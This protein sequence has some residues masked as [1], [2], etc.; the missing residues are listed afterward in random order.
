LK[1]AIAQLAPL[2]AQPG[3]DYVVVARHAAFDRPYPDIIADLHKAFSILHGGG[4]SNTQRAK[5]NLTGK[6]QP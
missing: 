5:N 6:S 4:G 2:R 3:F 1:A